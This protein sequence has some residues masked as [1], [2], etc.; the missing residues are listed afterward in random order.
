[1]SSV[2]NQNKD[3]AIEKL[4]RFGMG[5]KGVVFIILGV[6]TAM[7]AF[8]EGGQKAGQSDALK[9]IYNQPFGQVLLALLTVGLIGYVVWRFVQAF[10]DP[11]NEG[12]DKKG[13][14]KR[15]G[16]GASGVLYGF[17]AYEAVKMLVNSGSSGGGGGSKTVVGM[18]LEQ[19]FG[20]ILVGVI[21][22]ALF[23]KGASEIYKAVTEKFMKEINAGQLERK[24]KDIIRNV[25][26]VGLTARGI[27]VGIIGYLF[28]RAAI[29]SNS[30][31]AGGTESAFSFIQSSSYGSILLGIIAIGLACYGV[32]MIV[33][34]RYKALPSNM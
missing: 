2:T 12:D 3:E 5:A 27:V 4:A 13:L 33:K 32:Y 16:Y 29:E 34:A 14:A 20:Q 28:L 19:P 25:G 7:A 11:E 9:F 26:K 23:A 8:N 22:V 24:I 21:A 31:Q 1:M 30:S 18:L 10:R 6:L 15:I 17:L